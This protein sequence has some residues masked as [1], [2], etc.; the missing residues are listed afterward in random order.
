M[1]YCA[2]DMQVA[3]LVAA[4]TVSM[5]LSRRRVR[6]FFQGGRLTFDH[7]RAIRA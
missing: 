2:L 7:T 6:T 3:V 1:Y 5:R 4:A